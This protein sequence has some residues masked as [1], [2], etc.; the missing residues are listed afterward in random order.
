[1][2]SAAIWRRGDGLVTGAICHDAHAPVIEVAS[3]R[4]LVQLR[5]AVLAA[6]A[7]ALADL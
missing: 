6:L 4:Y 3:A 2:P 5:P 1:M 7:Q